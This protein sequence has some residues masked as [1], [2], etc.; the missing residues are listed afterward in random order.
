M[1]KTNFFKIS[2]GVIVV[3]FAY[4]LRAFSFLLLAPVFTR[5]IST[6]IWGSILAAQALAVWLILFL[7]FGF[8]L[9]MARYIAVER[10]D[11]KK[12][13]KHV[14]G[15]LSAKIMLIPFIMLLTLL[16]IQVGALS[17]VPSFA[18]WACVWA[19]AQGLSPVWYFQA[20]EEMKWFSL[21]D[22]LSRILYITLS[23]IFIRHNNDAYLVIALLAFTS[24]IT[25]ILTFNRM[26]N[27]VGGIK[28]S[29][30]SGYLALKEGITLSGFTLITSLYSTASVFIFGLLAPVQLVAIYGNADRLIRAGIG[31]MAPLNQILLPRS[32]RVFS[33]SHIDG[34]SLVKRYLILYGVFGITI[35]IIGLLAASVIINI[36][37][38]DKY[39]SS[40]HY[41]R[42]LLIL[43][44]F[45]A[46]NTVLAY[47][48][49][50]P[51]NN[52]KIM[53]NIYTFVSLIS[54]GLLYLLVPNLKGNGMIIAMLA[55]EILAFILLSLYTFKIYRASFR[56]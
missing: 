33:H 51:T 14:N 29:I 36:M 52:A 16:S 35:L 19:V 23:L 56:I 13:R 5:I 2:F 34:W 32:A 18:W 8:A 9:S 38:G 48:V 25:S 50:V 53:T 21:V 22:V 11:I 54:L 27:Q 46:I 41:L 28:I 30:H 4:F 31:I 43:V 6:D 12:V 40:V 44:P 3:Y 20:I 1:K 49:M 55:P 39:S 7:E 42:W 26:A 37:Y 10:D 17:K 24:G 47:H 45:T 15:I